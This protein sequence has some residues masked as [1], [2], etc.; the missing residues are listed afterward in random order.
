VA[1]LQRELQLQPESGIGQQAQVIA[2]LAS[3]GAGADELLYL[4]PPRPA[5]PRQVGDAERLAAVDPQGAERQPADR[6]VPPPPGRLSHAG[7]PARRVGPAGPL[8]ALLVADTQPTPGGAK[9]T[10]PDQAGGGRPS[11][12]H[13]GIGCGHEPI[14]VRP[15]LAFPPLMVGVAQPAVALPVWA[16]VHPAR[17]CAKDQVAGCGDQHLDA[18]LRP[19]RGQQPGRQPAPLRCSQPGRLAA[20][21]A[22]RGRGHSRTSRPV[23]QPAPSRVVRAS[24]TVRC[25]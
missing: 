2:H 5:P 18:E 17:R 16:A 21:S 11:S 3:G 22:D 25:P 19:D 12:D 6:P 14:Q 10:P 8:P 20:D 23:N 13:G 7:R 15:A 1:A 4:R 24:S 9:A